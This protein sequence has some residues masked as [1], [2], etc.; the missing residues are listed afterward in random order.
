MK[1]E[2]YHDDP[3]RDIP[4]EDVRLMNEVLEEMIAAENEPDTPTM[5]DTTAKTWELIRRLVF[6]YNYSS[7]RFARALTY[8]E[9]EH[10]AEVNQHLSDLIDTIGRSPA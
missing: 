7:D 2:I 9:Q 8:Y 4:I 3:T 6:L 5:K 10:L 1:D